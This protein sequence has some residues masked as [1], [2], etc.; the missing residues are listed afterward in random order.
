MPEKRKFKNFV[1]E[2][3]YVAQSFNMRFYEIL[4]LLLFEKKEAMQ[5]D[6][7]IGNEKALRYILSYV[8]SVCVLRSKEQPSVKA[9][10]IP[11]RFYLKKN[12]RGFCIEIPD[13]IYESQSKYVAYIFDEELNARYYSAEV[14]SEENKLGLCVKT[15]KDIHF[16][17]NKRYSLDISMDE[18]MIEALNHF[19]TPIL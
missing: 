1:E 12:L 13:A 19:E 6:K 7:L 10:D 17:L 9:S 15:A 11:F 16:S 14:Y 5:V 8:Y 3:M 18:F 2:G 4:S